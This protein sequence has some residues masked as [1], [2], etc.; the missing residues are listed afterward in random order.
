MPQR[1]NRDRTDREGTLLSS[2]VPRY[3]RGET[4]IEPPTAEPGAWAGAPSALSVD[5]VIWLA[6][7]YEAASGA[8]SHELRTELIAAQPLTPDSE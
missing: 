2:L 5:G 7:Y 1:R 6:Y 4:A 8:G 3:E